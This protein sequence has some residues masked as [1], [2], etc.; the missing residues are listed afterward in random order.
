MFNKELAQQVYFCIEIKPGLRTLKK[1]K[2]V[3]VIN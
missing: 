1:G 2:V 3:D